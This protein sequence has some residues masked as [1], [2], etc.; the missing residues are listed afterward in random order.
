[1]FAVLYNVF[2]QYLAV[3][4]LYS[5]NN[6]DVLAGVVGYLAFMKYHVEKMCTVKVKT[7]VKGTRL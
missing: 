5:Q 4:L 6:W 3:H 7:A 1:V 2:F